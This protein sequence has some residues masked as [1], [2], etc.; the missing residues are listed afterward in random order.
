MATWRRHPGGPAGS[1]DETPSARVPDGPPAAASVP[2]VRVDQVAAAERC[3]RLLQDT[4]RAVRPELAWQYGVQRTGARLLAPGQAQGAEIGVGAGGVDG[5]HWYV[6]RSREIVTI[7]SGARRGMLLALVERH[8]RRHGHL[9]VGCDGD[10]E[11]PRIAAATRDGYRLELAFGPLGSA[12]LTAVSPGVA[13]SP[14][15]P[16]APAAARAAADLAPVPQ[17]RCPFWTAFD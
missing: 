1:L 12:E 16:E 14:Q 9:V 4:L 6:G 11:C 7:V 8:W 10:P 15:P 13:R 3:E 5:V 17:V 2:A